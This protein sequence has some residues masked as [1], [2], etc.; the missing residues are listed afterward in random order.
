M[1]RSWC[2]LGW[3]R[4]PGPR[5]G[6]SG[7]L[8]AV[9]GLAVAYAGAAGLDAVCAMR[10]LSLNEDAKR[11]QV[12]RPTPWRRR[13]LAPCWRSQGASAPR[14]GPYR[15]TQTPAGTALVHHFDLV[16]HWRLAAP[17]DPVWAALANPETWPRWWP[18]LQAVQLVR[19]GGADGIGSVRHFRWAIALCDPLCNSV[20]MEVEWLE[21]LRHERIRC[22]C[23]GP[24]GGECI[25]LLRAEAAGTADVFTDVTCV[26]R[27][28]LAKRWLRWAAPLLVPWFR[29]HHKRLM[30][31]G[32]TGLAHYLTP[33]GQRH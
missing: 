17:I 15:F 21:S 23:S 8:P 4:A 22:R 5:C 19:A 2:Q 29:W 28:Q 7:L 12:R 16:S 10:P 33:G 26:W 25:W 18:R 20:S 24:L 31:A 27:V 13:C 32:A 30:Q 14:P 1:N 11:G 3:T 6:G 9:S